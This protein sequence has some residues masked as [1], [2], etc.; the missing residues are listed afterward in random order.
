MIIFL[1]NMIYIVVFEVAVSFISALCLYTRINWAMKFVHTP[2]RK[3]T[4]QFKQFLCLVICFLL[5]LFLLCLQ[6]SLV[7]CCRRC[8]P[9]SFLHPFLLWAHKLLLIQ[10]CICIPTP[11]SHSNWHVC[12]LRKALCHHWI[13]FYIIDIC[14]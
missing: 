13:V 3:K 2:V 14:C 5:L 6:N 10:I 1:H 4:S 9:F 12:V 7:C 8:V 11:H